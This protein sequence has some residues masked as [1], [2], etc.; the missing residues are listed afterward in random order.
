MPV[1]RSCA[2]AA[3]VASVGIVLA[4]SPADAR[5][6]CQGDRHMHYGSGTGPTKKVAM[7]NALSSWSGFTAFEYGNAYAYWKHARFKRKNC[8]RASGGWSCNIS[9][10]PCRVTR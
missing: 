8:E 10:N 1:T 9:A 2:L 6:Y 3:L 7:R 5:K 4:S